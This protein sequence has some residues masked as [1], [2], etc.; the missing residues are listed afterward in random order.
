MGFVP[1]RPLLPQIEQSHE[2]LN[3]PAQEDEPR[4]GFRPRKRK[5]DPLKSEHPTNMSKHDHIVTVCEDCGEEYYRGKGHVC[6]DRK[7]IYT[8]CM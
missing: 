5:P 2:A 3:A 6:F 8:V 1:P 7:L 4:I